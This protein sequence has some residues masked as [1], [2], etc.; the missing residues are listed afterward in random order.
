[1]T[2]KKIQLDE[3][4][5]QTK[6]FYSIKGSLDKIISYNEIP[7]KNKAEALRMELAKLEDQNGNKIS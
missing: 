3:I 1:M 7:D 4:I 5:V 6:I 2:D